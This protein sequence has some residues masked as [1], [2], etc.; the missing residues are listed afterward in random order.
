[1]YT[2]LVVL[3]RYGELA[4]K[5]RYV[6]RQLEDRLVTN[7]REMFAANEVE[8]ILHSE[9]GRVFVHAE[10]EGAA[11]RLLRRV[12]GIVSVSPAE[13]APSDLEALTREVVAYA[14]GVLEPGT[15]FAIRARRSG[16]HPYTSPELARVLGR[17]VQDAIP[18]LA[19]NLDAPD[20]QI[21]VDVRGPRA[22]VF[23]EVV[24]GPGGLP[25]GSQGKV[26]API[27]DDE[28]L[29]AAWLMMR[30]GCRVVAAGD[31][32]TV[33]ILRKW[34]PQLI[35]VNPAVGD[36]LVRLAAKMRVPFLAVP[37]RDP[38]QA[39]KAGDVP[40]LVSHPLIGL[41]D[42]EVSRLSRMVHAA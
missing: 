17:A 22:Y 32:P 12:F 7:V 6:R 28:G 15:S 3:V 36:G 9:R 20:R 25:L 24:K 18:D 8:C 30:R 38:A 34:D 40:V 26:L 16:E 29:V 21:H 19:V 11:L 2:S 33:S 4:L 13:E 5:S 42:A 39:S 1:M 35:V 37:D 31:E 14:R 23:H 10:D 27:E 41:A